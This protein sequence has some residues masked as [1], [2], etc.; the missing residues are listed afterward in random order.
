MQSDVTVSQR[1]L[2]VP[3]RSECTNDVGSS[4]LCS[5]SPLLTHILAKPGAYRL[6]SAVSAPT[7]ASA[8]IRHARPWLALYLVWQS[9]L[10]SSCRA[11]TRPRWAVSLRHNSQG[12]HEGSTKAL[13]FEPC[14][15]SSI[16]RS[17]AKLEEKKQLYRVVL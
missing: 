16:P 11:S 6:S 12:Q 10:K 17:H 13:P 8:G 3:V 1:C 4:P 5:P 7:S 14:D 2:R 9:K 15:V